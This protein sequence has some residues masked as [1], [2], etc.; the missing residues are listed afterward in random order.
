[1]SGTLW[2]VTAYKSV[3][4]LFANG[5]YF[6]RARLNVG[7]PGVAREVAMSLIDEA[8][9]GATTWPRPK[10]RQC[11]KASSKERGHERIRQG[12]ATGLE[13]TPGCRA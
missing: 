1:M 13:H 11:A 8:H 12:V 5:G 10:R 9:K 4:S 2:R 6:L 7:P 3:G